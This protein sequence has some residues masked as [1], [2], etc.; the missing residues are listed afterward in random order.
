[1]N[2]NAFEK[3]MY[4]IRNYKLSWR[5]SQLYLHNLLFFVHTVLFSGIIQMR[6]IQKIIVFHKK[7]VQIIVKI[8]I[9]FGTKKIKI[10]AISI[11][12]SP[13]ND[14]LSNLRKKA[15]AFGHPPFALR[16]CAVPIHAGTAVWGK[17][18][19]TML[20]ARLIRTAPGSPR[21]GALCR[22]PSRERSRT[23]RSQGRGQTRTCRRR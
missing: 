2:E 1:M 11:E 4:A 19:I 6:A 17:V 15:D 9:F 14:I 23:D 12:I 10:T 20:A 7:I 5:K 3:M 21:A 16:V 13:K 18:R 22:C 8:A